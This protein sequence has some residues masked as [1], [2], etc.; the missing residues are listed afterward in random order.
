MKQLKKWLLAGGFSLAVLLTFY[1]LWANGAEEEVIY[2][3]VSVQG[4]DDLSE[5]LTLTGKIVPRDQVEIKP[6][7]AG[8]ISELLVEPGTQ[9]QAGD[10]I[11]RISVVP[12]MMQVSNAEAQLS[13]IRISHERLRSVHERN[14]SLY[15]A[16]LLSKEELERSEAELKQARVRLDAAVEG[17]ELIRRGVS[18]RSS[19]E[20]TTLVRSTISGKVLS[21]PVKV[22]TSVIQANTFNPGTTI[23]VVANMSDLIFEGNADETEIGKLQLGQ[24]MSITVGALPKGKL[25]AV[26]DYIAPQGETSGSITRF[27]IKGGIHGLSQELTAQIRSGYSA[28]AEILIREAKNTLS[29][30]EGCITYRNDSTYV[31]YVLQEEPLQT[32]ERPVE[33]GL[34]TGAKVEVRSGLMQGDKVR[35]N[36][37]YNH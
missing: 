20:S 18:S 29:L 15:D 22:G 1:Y 26:I 5:M 36:V 2:E 10:I 16:E 34:S 24:R 4:G 33:L 14:Q 32:E 30:P 21:I 11:A 3:L 23:A 27:P 12:E 19:K 25:S 28:N 37:V 13:E 6:Q 17:L 9:V 35:G 31:Q 8:I 7:I